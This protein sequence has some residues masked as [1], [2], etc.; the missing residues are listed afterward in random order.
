MLFLLL[1]VQIPFS[2][3]FF[4]EVLCHNHVPKPDAQNLQQHTHTSGFDQMFTLMHRAVD[5]QSMQRKYI[6]LD[7]LYV[8]RVGKS[9]VK[10]KLFY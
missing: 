8:F 10:Y 1:F 5:R 2:L 9:S 6:K 4:A 7:Y 3:T